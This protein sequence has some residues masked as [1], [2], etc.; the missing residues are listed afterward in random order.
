MKKPVF[1]K[2][3][4]WIKKSLTNSGL[5]SVCIIQCVTIH[6]VMTN[7]W[8]HTFGPYKLVRERERERARER[9][10]EGEKKNRIR[11]MEFRILFSH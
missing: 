11:I 3:I 10:G 9:V 8:P 5:I 2:F 6:L 7:V 4:E 1:G